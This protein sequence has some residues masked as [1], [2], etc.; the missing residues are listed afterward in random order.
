MNLRSE[1]IGSMLAEARRSAGLTV[2]QLST[3]TRVRE[4]LIYAIERDDFSQC[5]GDFYVKGHIRNIAK[6]VG[7]DPEATVRAYD[8]AREGAP[9]PPVRAARVFQAEN[10]IKLRERRSPNWSMA[11]GIALAI[12]VIFGVVRGMGGE[13]ERRVAEVRSAVPGAAAPSGT[14]SAAPSGKGSGKPGRGRD[15]RPSRPAAGAAAPGRAD[16]VELRVSARQP[17]WVRVQDAEGKRLFS[18]MI[19]AG[20]TA[21]WTADKQLRVVIGNAGGVRLEVNGEDLGVPGRVGEIVRRS[22]GPETATPAAGTPGEVSRER[23]SIE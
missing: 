15:A 1:S 19:Q 5:G 11:L 20:K 9:A 17:S 23:G 3:R 16:A 4:A 6:V 14:P 8:E 18:G 21:S 22:F 10:Q 13:S 7:L 2:G 12:V